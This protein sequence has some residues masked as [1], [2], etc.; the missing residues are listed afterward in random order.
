MNARFLTAFLSILC[1]LCG[2][3]SLW[4]NVADFVAVINTPQRLEMIKVMGFSQF[5]TA[6]RRAAC[7]DRFS[8]SVLCG[9][10]SL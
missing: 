6:K 3:K 5:L 8:L 1:A 10:K 2:K 7:P 4:R 9:K